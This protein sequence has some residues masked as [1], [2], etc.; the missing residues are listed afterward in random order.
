MS[1]TRF[2]IQTAAAAIALFILGL[3]SLEPSLFKSLNISLVQG[4]T[5]GIVCGTMVLV[6]MVAWKGIEITDKQED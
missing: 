6:L 5:F 3:S 2:K 1:R 4:T